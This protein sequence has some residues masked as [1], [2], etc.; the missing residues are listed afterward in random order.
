MNGN[1]TISV[2][3]L[4][5]VAITA[6]GALTPAQS[7]IT[8]GRWRDINPTQYATAPAEGP[9]RGIYLRSGGTGYIGAGEGWAVGGAPGVPILSHY[10]GFSWELRGSPI[11][12]A[13]YNSVHFCTAPGAPSV[14]LCSPNGD[15]TDGW[16][17]GTDGAAARA[18]YV[19]N[20]STL[21]EVST[22]LAPA[23][24]LTSVFMVCHSPP[25]GTGCPGALSAGRT[26]AAGQ[27][28]GF[29][30]IYVFNGDPLNGG[31]WTLQFTSALTSKFNSIY[32]FWDGSQLGGFAVGNGGIVARLNSGAWNDVAIGGGATDLLGV[33]VDNGNPIDAWAVGKSGQIW[34]FATGFWS[35]FV[36]PL[37]TGSDLVSVFLT[38]TSEGWIVG[39]ESATLH[40]TNLGSGNTWLGI[41]SPL[42]TATGSGIDL[43]SLSFPS[44]GNGWSVGTEGV[45]LHTE[46]SNCGNAVPGPCWG[47]STSITQSLQ[48]KAVFMKGSNDAWAGG[49]YDTV[50][51]TPSLIHWDGNKWHR[52][53][54]YGGYLVTLPD[55]WG[56]YMLSSSEAWAVGGNTAN[57]APAALK[58]DGSSW[59]SQPV[60]ACTCSLRSVYMISGGTGGDGWAVGSDGTDG[61]GANGFIYRYQSGS[62]LQFMVVPGFP[63][64]GVF[65]S[66]PGS[67]SNAGWAVGN[68]GKVLKLTIVSGV[69]TWSTVGP[70]LGVTADLFGVYFTDSNHGWMV[71]GKVGSQ[72]AV[73]L[74]TS[75]GGTTWSGGAGQVTGAPAGT[76]LRSVFID[77]YGTGSGN[78][79]GWA[80]GNTMTVETAGN[81]VFAHWDGGTW[82]AVTV[83]P[84][85]Q[86]GL[87]LRSVYVRDPNDGFAVGSGTT[88]GTPL[89]AIFHLDPPNPPTSLPPTT[90]STVSGST[91][92][93]TAGGGTETSTASTAS[94][95][96]STSTSAE[97]GASSVTYQ[98]STSTSGSVVTTQTL[99]TQTLSQFTSSATTPLVLPAVPGFPWESILAGIILGFATL[100]VMRR[101]RRS[102]HSS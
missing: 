99:S 20:P 72:E 77:T 86:T 8:Y 78:G 91:T 15:G 40:S 80:V 41:T 89:A 93:T 94:T 76:V 96:S 2:V 66:N 52:A 18:L 30:V 55:I 98:V 36:S 35:G 32:M 90:A 84:S 11:A 46:N 37:G 57:T 58:W 17:V 47:G 1:R 45:I 24:N 88:P 9:L 73:I 26:Y 3:V 62:W 101:R 23:T 10:D 83:S 87:A 31:G 39:T 13:V 61:G 65:I 4:F 12:G 53:S 33:F 69:P 67:S 34:R 6:L 43:L 81:A 70:I 92:G 16:I 38:S 63:L 64:N 14:G 44:G 7:A 100:A 22:G 59:T 51:N 27:S 97:T 85:L 49:L 42:Q 21:T 28:G 50:S 68:D 25:Y 48:L 19:S 60:A 79:D 54:V 74:T 29:G 56:I 102:P 95:E 75:D 82:G 5:I 71:G